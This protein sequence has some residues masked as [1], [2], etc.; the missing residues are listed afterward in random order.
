MRR[1]SR[2][3]CIEGGKQQQMINARSPSDTPSQNCS[4]PDYYTLF[5]HRIIEHYCDLSLDIRSCKSRMRQTIYSAD[6][7]LVGCCC[8]RRSILRYA[9]Y[10]ALIGSSF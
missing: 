9:Q 7:A 5:E 2:K 10:F 6:L 8:F 3:A 1:D 4:T